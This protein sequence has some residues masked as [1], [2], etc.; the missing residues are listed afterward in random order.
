MLSSAN[1]RGLHTS[2]APWSLQ[3]LHGCDDDIPAA[4]VLNERE[5]GYYPIHA[6]VACGRIQMYD[7]LVQKCAAGNYHQH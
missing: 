7:L 6:V 3:V 4:E 1:Q 5:K 2:H